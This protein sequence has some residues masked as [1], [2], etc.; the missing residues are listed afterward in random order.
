MANKTLSTLPQ[1]TRRWTE[2][3][4]PW[5]DTFWDDDLGLIWSPSA[6]PDQPHHDVRGTIWYTL[7]LLLRGAAGDWTRRN[8]QNR[9]AFQ[10]VYLIISLC[11]PSARF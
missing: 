7:G 9:L 4:L 3:T 8:G 11:P 10:V 6:G 5:L 1:H 2:K